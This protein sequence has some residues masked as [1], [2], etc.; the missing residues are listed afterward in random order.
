MGR[1]TQTEPL[2]NECKS[3]LVVES[4]I[5]ALASYHRAPLTFSSAAGST[6][7][8]AC[9]DPPCAC[10]CPYFQVRQR[11]RREDAAGAEICAWLQDCQ[12]QQ[13]GPPLAFAPTHSQ[14]QSHTGTSQHI[15]Q[16][17]AN[18][19]QNAMGP[20]PSEVE[21]GYKGSLRFRR[22]LLAIC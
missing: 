10:A 11:R 1:D 2:S 8:C 3:I 9:A 22:L 5:R 13:G 19:I 18:T 20:E 12:Q 14:I 15:M 4:S 16:F 17:V 21:A 6:I 7:C